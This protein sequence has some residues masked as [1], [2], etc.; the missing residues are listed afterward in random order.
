MTSLFAVTNIATDE[1]KPTH[2]AP[3]PKQEKELFQINLI[4][5]TDT[6]INTQHKHI[7]T[8]LIFQHFN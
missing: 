8:Q 2:R 7:K 5:L 3:D 6:K 4:I 1:I